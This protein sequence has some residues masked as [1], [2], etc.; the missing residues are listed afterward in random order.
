MRIF[1]LSIFSL[2][3]LTCDNSPT[4]TLIEGCIDESACNYDALADEDDGTCTYAEENFD[5]DGECIAE[6]DCNDECGGSAVL[7]ECGECDGGNYAMDCEGVCDGGSGFDECGICGGSGLNADGC[8]GDETTDCA[9]VCGGDNTACEDCNGVED[10]SAYLDNCGVCDSISANDCVQDCLGTWGGNATYDLCGT[11]DDDST[12]DCVNDCNGVLGGSAF[13]DDCGQCVGG[14][15][16]L[17]ENYLF[18]E[19]NVCNG[20]GIPEGECDCNGNVLDVCGICGGNGSSCYPDFTFYDTQTYMPTW[21]ILLFSP[22]TFELLHTRSIN[23]NSYYNDDQDDIAP[24]TYYIQFEDSL[25]GAVLSEPLQLITFEAGKDYIISSQYNSDYYNQSPNNEYSWIF[26]LNGEIYCLE[27]EGD[28]D[29]ST[30]S[31]C[32]YRV[33]KIRE[34]PTSEFPYCMP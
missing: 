17:S 30:Y 3:I 7:D 4:A 32:E 27:Y 9:G 5:C 29:P 18:D 22:V 19:C 31:P 12:N 26:E 21:H 33:N 2:L 16:G 20:S 11:C 15:T 8:C 25:N 23:Q 1:L 6:L 24:G 10:G 14:T 28:I 13:I 34:C